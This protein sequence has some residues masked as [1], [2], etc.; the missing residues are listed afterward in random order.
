MKKIAKLKEM[1][2][3]ESIRENDFKNNPSNI[4]VVNIKTS[5]NKINQKN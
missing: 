3:N 1:K 4:G 5:I 2:L